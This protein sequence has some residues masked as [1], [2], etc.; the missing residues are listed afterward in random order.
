MLLRFCFSVA[1]ILSF[2]VAVRGGESAQAVFEKAAGALAA[3]DYPE[4]ERGFLAVLKAEPSNVAALGNLGVVYSRTD[5]QA[6]AIEVYRQAL[7]IAPRDRGLITNLGLAYVKQEQFAKALPIFERLGADPANLQ[8]REL[9]ATC[10]LALG[11]AESALAILEPLHASDPANA[12][13]LY[14]LGV[15]YSKLK[16]TA[17][18][19]DAFARMMQSVKPAQA[20][21]LMG[22]A[23]YETGDFEHAAEYFRQSLKDDPESRNV[24]R[25]LG[26]TLISLRDN[27]NA[28]SELRQAGMDDAEALYFLGG[29]LAQAGRRDAIPILLKARDVNPEAW[30]PLYYLG[31]VYLDLGDVRQA[32]P[33]LERAA[34]LKPDEAAIQYQLGRALQKAGRPAGASAAFARV[35]ELKA[36]SLKSEIDVLSSGREP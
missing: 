1:L 30:G 10:R 36:R 24:H 17:E 3:R 27:D 18:A 20:N 5:R 25:E 28:E 16:R 11:N 31:R 6:K 29:L 2:P 35:K 13:V 23:S 9:L 14:M 12:G 15:A 22:K 4:A 34:K 33:V 8:A 21:F 19:H 32:L 7:R 26:K